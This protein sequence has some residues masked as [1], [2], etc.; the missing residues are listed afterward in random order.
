MQKQRLNEPSEKQEIST[1]YSLNRFSVAPM[2]DWTDRHCRAFH[3]SLTKNALLYTEMVTTGAILF[4]KGD[5]LAYNDCEH[6]VALQ[7]GGSDPIALAKCAKIAED[8]GYDEINLNVGC[9]SDRVQNGQFG[10]C[11][12]TNAKLVHDCIAAMRDVTNVPITVKSRI[13]IDEQDSYAFLCDFIETVSDASETFII[14]ARKAWLSGLS[15]KENRNIPP[16]DYPRVYQLKQDFPH[17]TIAINGGITSLTDAKAHLQHVD[18]VMIGREAYQNPQILRDVDALLF[19]DAPQM[20]S[21]KAQIEAFFPYIETELQK[22]VKLSHITRH[23]IGYFR[24]V[25]GA[26][27]YRQYLSENAHKIGA[28]LKTLETALS[29]IHE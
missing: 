10:A 12:M 13:G 19:N 6:P 8:R 17:L 14:H 5:Y 20:L 18:G 1:N 22:D 24:E 26:K 27:L 25:K 21:A 15:P 2:L 3:R 29:F 11:L 4:G 9:P 16:L 28:D 7:L 23:M